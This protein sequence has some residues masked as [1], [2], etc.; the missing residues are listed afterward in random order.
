MKGLADSYDYNYIYCINPNLDFSDEDLLSIDDDNLTKQDKARK[1]RLIGDNKKMIDQINKM[2]GE[3]TSEGIREKI[4]PLEN[5]PLKKA[6]KTFCDRF[7]GHGKGLE[8][9]PDD[10]NKV[11]NTYNYIKLFYDK[12]FVEIKKIIKK[13]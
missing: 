9:K 7:I 11:K 10:S 6:V 4:K 8:L 13:A 3:I 12:E 5:S 2:L 1:D